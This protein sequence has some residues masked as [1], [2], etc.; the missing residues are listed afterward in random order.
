MIRWGAILLAGL[1]L[2]SGGYIIG[3]DEQGVLRRCGRLDPELRASGLHWDWPAPFVQVTRIK[4]SA[5]QTVRV[6]AVIPLPE[7]LFSTTTDAPWGLLTRDQN[8]VRVRAEVHYRLDPAQIGQALFGHVDRD[9]LLRSLLESG[10]IETAAGVDVDVLQTSGLSEL[11][12][13][14]T[15]RLRDGIADVGLGVVIDRV[16]L[17]GVDPYPEVL[18][19]FLDVA[20]A[21]SEGT[22]VMQEARTFAEQQVTAAETAAS[23]RIAAARGKGTTRTIAATATASRFTQLVDEL[24]QSAKNTG[25]TYEAHRQRYTRQLTRNLYRDLLTQGL[26]T[27]IVSGND[28]Q[29]QFLPTANQ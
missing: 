13:Q 2:A 16:T 25:Q 17:E 27:W 20:N 9:R 12:T 26:Q 8:L 10:L 14:L 23:E 11:Q 5:L 4:S 28:V 24:Q 6:G 29:L 15:Q 22:R 7:A 3:G 1:Y 18:A 19:D 21:R